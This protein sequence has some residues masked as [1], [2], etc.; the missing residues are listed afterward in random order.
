[1]PSGIAAAVVLRVA[2]LVAVRAGAL[3]ALSIAILA[4]VML[5]HSR[6]VHPVWL[7]EYLVI[8]TMNRRPGL[9][10]VTRLVEEFRNSVMVIEVAYLQSQYCSVLVGER[11]RRVN[12][13]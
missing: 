7:Y 11:L 12:S 6:C 8:E 5:P 9:R 4:V 3:R 10:S 1:M 13:A 2:G